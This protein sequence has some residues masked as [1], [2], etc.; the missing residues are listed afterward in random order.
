M[1][2]HILAVVDGIPIQHCTQVPRPDNEHPVGHLG[3]D[4]PDPALGIS[5]RRRTAWR[6]LH[7]LDPRAGEYRV[8]CAGELPGPVPDQETE[9]GGAL[10]QVHQRVPGLLYCPRAVRMRGHAQDMHMTSA[11]LED[12]DHVH[13]AQ[14]DGAVD[15]K[16]VAGKHG[17]GLGAQELRPGR[18]AAPRGGL[19][20]QSVQHPPHGRGADADARAEQFARPWRPTTG[21]AGPASCR[22]GRR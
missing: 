17:R 3:P 10:F 13:A 16:E 5:I 22:A 14:G 7:Y 9:P 20:P 2:R 1:R 21:R 4:R 11:D 6:D 18:T 15:M 8:E 19:D 12:E